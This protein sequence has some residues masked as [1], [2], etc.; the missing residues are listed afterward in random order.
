M[1]RAFLSL[2]GLCLFIGCAG[3]QAALSQDEQTADSGSDAP[4]SDEL[5]VPVN[6]DQDQTPKPELLSWRDVT[7][8]LPGNEGRK[9]SMAAIAADIDGDKDLDIIVAREFAGNRL[10]INDGKGLFS[11]PSQPFADE[12]FDSE[13]IVA[14]D[15]N[16]DE[17]LDVLFVSEDN[18]EDE[19]YLNNGEGQFS[20]AESWLPEAQVTN[21]VAAEDID[22]DGQPEVFLAN[23]GQNVVWKVSGQTFEQIDIL[24]NRQDIS[25]SLELGDL[26]GD[27]DLDLVIGNED[28]NRVL[29]LQD[30]GRYVD[31]PL[32]LRDT[33]EETREA[34]LGDVDGDGDLDIFFANTQLFVSGANL[35][36]RLLLNNGQA[37]FTDVTESHLPEDTDTTMTAAFV[38]LT[39]DGYLDLI[40]GS[41]DDIRAVEAKAPYR[42][43]VN[44]GSGHFSE[45]L[46]FPDDTLGNGFGILP[47]D[48]NG[49]SKV[50]IFLGSRG[51]VDR[52]LYSS[53]ERTFL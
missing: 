8:T 44:D 27:G 18:R 48:F 39:G 32:P 26:D 13:D 34:I 11:E 19:L 10:F 42:T 31:I 3:R 17:L 12:S 51:G 21:G 7:S 38:D 35:Q 4:N 47:A 28:A 23:N 43:Y 6:E 45:Q 16:G 37:E 33:P 5:P 53:R 49:D 14:R 52:L 9:L 46:L 41:I 15:F 25:Q 30:D 50:D 40:T 29:L 36:S 20:L 24:P 1:G 2:L 22:G